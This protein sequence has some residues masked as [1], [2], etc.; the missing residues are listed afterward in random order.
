[1]KVDKIVLVLLAAFAV[2]GCSL[3][4]EV[5]QKDINKR[6]SCSDTR[7]GQTFTFKASTIANA[8]VGVGADTCFD[9]TTDSGTKMNLCKSHEAWLKCQ[10]VN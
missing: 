4:A 1:M 8:T 3:K 2:Q 9:I 5:A 7:D 10:E 6:M